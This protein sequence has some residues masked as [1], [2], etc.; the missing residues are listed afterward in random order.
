MYKHIFGPVPSRRLGISLGVDL[1]LSKSWTLI[2][3]F[4]NVVLL[5]KIQLE[6]TEGLKIWNEILNEI[7]ILYL[8]GIIKL[9]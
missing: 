4:V 5:K 3:S 7:Q 6:K 9:T 2:V 8:K 1:V